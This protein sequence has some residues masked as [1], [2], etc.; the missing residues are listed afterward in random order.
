MA[1]ACPITRLGADEALQASKT[2]TPSS[3]ISP[4]FARLLDALARHAAAERN[5]QGADYWAEGTLRLRV[6]TETAFTDVATLLSAIQRAPLRAHG[7]EALQEMASLIDRMIG[8]EEAG[9][10]Q[11]LHWRLPRLASPDSCRSGD[12]APDTQRLL[13][14]ARRMIGALSR[15]ELYGTTPRDRGDDDPTCAMNAF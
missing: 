8:S 3:W 6:A 15:L 5:L 13:L 7:D 14:S 12:L 11:R 9:M 4:L 1:A 10:F 2:T